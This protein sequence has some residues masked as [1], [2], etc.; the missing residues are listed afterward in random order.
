MQLNRHGVDTAMLTSGNP[1]SDLL[2]HLDGANRFDPG[3]EQLQERR[4]AG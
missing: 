2:T 3:Q 4:T 1:V